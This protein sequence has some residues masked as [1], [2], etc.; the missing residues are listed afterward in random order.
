MD[1]KLPNGLLQFDF[2]KG[3][4]LL[5]HDTLLDKLRIY[6]CSHS[7]MLPRETAPSISSYDSFVFRSVLGV[8]SLMPTSAS[9]PLFLKLKWIPVFYSPPTF[10]FL[11]S[12]LKTNI[13]NL[14]PTR[15]SSAEHLEDLLCSICC[16]SIYCKCSS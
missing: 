6:G 3:S 16:Y 10:K 8:Y 7:S 5:D 15:L 12:F 2:K 14:F 9:L 1:N 13:R 11:P 4:D